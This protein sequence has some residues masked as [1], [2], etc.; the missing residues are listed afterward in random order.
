MTQGA[1][2]MLV[3]ENGR[4]FDMIGSANNSMLNECCSSILQEASPSIE[5]LSQFE[6]GQARLGLLLG[7]GVES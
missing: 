3:R 2:E 1:V 4:S 7:K 6:C 5:F